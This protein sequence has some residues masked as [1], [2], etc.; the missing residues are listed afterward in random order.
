MI[1]I[2]LKKID[3]VDGATPIITYNVNMITS[4]RLKAQVPIKGMDLAFMKQYGID[5]VKQGR[6][7]T[8]KDSFGVLFGKETLYNF[9][10]STE[11]VDESEDFDELFGAKKPP[12]FNPIGASVYMSFGM[13]LL[14]TKRVVFNR[15]P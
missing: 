5:K 3:G 6:S 15:S 9:S 4:D 13:E 10:R 8:E 2:N 7:L 11:E 1:L 14:V 12:K